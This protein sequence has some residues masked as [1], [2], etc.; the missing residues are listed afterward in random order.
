[1]FTPSDARKVS[2]AAADFKLFEE[3]IDA[4]LR[5][6]ARMGWPSDFTHVLDNC[7]HWTAVEV[8]ERYRTAGWKVDVV[9]VT[10]ANDRVVATNRQRLTF[11]LTKIPDRGGPNDR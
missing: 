11:A 4:G 7:D 2:A 8:A 3:N 10:N 5:A 1:M 9:D 6:H